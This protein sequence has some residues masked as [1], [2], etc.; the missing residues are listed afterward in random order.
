[1]PLHMYVGMHLKKIMMLNK[2]ILVKKIALRILVLFYF[3]LHV[4][5]TNAQSNVSKI[6]GFIEE[7]CYK[8]AFLLLSERQM[9]LKKSIADSKFN[10]SI[11]NVNDFETGILYFGIDS[12]RTYQEVKERRNEGVQESKSI[13]LDD[14]V[15]IYIKDDIQSAK[16]I[17]GKNTSALNA[18]NET[19][20]TKKYLDF[21][22]IYSESP[23][24]LILLKALLLIE[25]KTVYKMFLDYEKIYFKIP[26][27]LQNSKRGLEVKSLLQK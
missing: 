4:L 21:F 20:K 11:N 8:Y 22:E 6:N 23:V 18:M 26:L 14:S 10:F 15:N 19:A 3:S 27:K 9:L 16:I 2:N 5:I 1:M 24:A 12:N 17:G 13:V 25:K 7:P